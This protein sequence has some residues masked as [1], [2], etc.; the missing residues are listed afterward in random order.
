MSGFLMIV[1]H[2]NHGSHTGFPPQT[3]TIQNSLDNKNSDPNCPSLK[4]AAQNKKGPRKPPGTVCTFPAPALKLSPLPLGRHSA[5]ELAAAESRNL[6][7]EDL[8]LCTL[9]AFRASAFLAGRLLPAPNMHR[10]AAHGAVLNRRGCSLALKSPKSRPRPK[11]PAGA[12]SWAY[13]LTSPCPQ[14][15]RAGRA[16]MLGVSSF[17]P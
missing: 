3:Y 9:L 17:K 13:L 16:P 4:A 2:E 14:D 8:I 15:Q 1:G 11:T 7:L 6:F 10:I 5:A 12:L